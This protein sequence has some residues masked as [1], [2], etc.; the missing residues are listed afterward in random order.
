MLKRGRC[1][2]CCLLSEKNSLSLRLLFFLLKYDNKCDQVD[3]EKDDENVN[4]M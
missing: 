4:V 1:C 3:G 2:V